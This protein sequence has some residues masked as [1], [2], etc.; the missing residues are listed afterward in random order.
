MTPPLRPL[1]FLAAASVLACDGL[2]IIEPVPGT[3]V[4]IVAERMA[5]DALPSRSVTG[6][7]GLVLV[8]APAGSPGADN[9]FDAV[10]GRDSGGRY[11]LR[12]TMETRGVNG[13]AHFYAYR[14]TVT[15]LTPG[16]YAVTVEE[17]LKTPPVEVARW[18]G[19]A[20]VE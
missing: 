8:V 17:R 14:A 13:E 5:E 2:S 18:T 6:G 11:V 4:E 9:R 10:F 15:G 16:T 19:Q 12:V 1:A 7:P 3:T 20:I